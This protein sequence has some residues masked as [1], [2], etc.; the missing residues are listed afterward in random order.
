MPPKVPR[1][2]NR[3]E[4]DFPRYS[5]LQGLLCNDCFED[6]LEVLAFILPQR[7][8]EVRAELPRQRAVVDLADVAALLR[9][10]GAA[11]V[12]QDW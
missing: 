1:I 8:G 11:A 9:A 10:V 2:R 5:G 3:W 4:G 7:L 6:D 12:P